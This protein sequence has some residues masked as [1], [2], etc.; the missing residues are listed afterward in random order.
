MLLKGREGQLKSCG[1]G[2]GKGAGEA[3]TGHEQKTWALYIL[4]EMSPPQTGT[5]RRASPVCKL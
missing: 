1:V 4:W 5:A 2:I 3:K